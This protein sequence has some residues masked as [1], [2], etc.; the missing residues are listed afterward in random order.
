MS[1]WGLEIGEGRREEIDPL[2]I[3]FLAGLPL[4]ALESNMKQTKEEQEEKETSRENI[5]ANRGNIKE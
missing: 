3:C 1:S 5:K 2:Q 4:P